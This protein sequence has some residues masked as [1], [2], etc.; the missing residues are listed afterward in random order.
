MLPA[1]IKP[2][3]KITQALSAR[4]ECRVGLIKSDRATIS[5]AVTGFLGGR[6]DCGLPASR[7]RR[8]VGRGWS[9]LWRDEDADRW[10]SFIRKKFGMNTKSPLRHAWRKKKD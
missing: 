10:A 6:G 3:I 4:N 7:S 8:P 9:I 5:G 2:L 1:R